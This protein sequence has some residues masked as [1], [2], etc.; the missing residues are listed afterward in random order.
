[1]RRLTVSLAL[2]LVFGA[3]SASAAEITLAGYAYGCFFSTQ[4]GSCTPLDQ[5]STTY[6]THELFYTTGAFGGTT[7][8]G[9]VPITL[10]TFS[11]LPRG[12]DDYSGHFFNLLLTFSAP[13]GISGSNP[14]FSSVITGTTSSAP[15]QCN[16]SAAPCG[17]V[18]VNFNNTPLAFAFTNGSNTGS[19]LLTMID[20]TIGAGQTNV[21][22]T[23]LITAG[24]L[25]T[26]TTSTSVPEPGMLTL[27]G[28]GIAGL[29][30]RARRSRARGRSPQA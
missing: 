6:R 22:L 1:M 8:G 13:A 24:S 15:G 25:N 16:P 23:A 2:V 21:P 9:T 29:V 7:V 5:D 10:G 17:S 11:L 30:A 28:A 27:L 14:V 3:G 18:T 19:F 26:L 4:D 12:N 20:L